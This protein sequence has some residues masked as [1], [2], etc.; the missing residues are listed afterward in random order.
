M[1]TRSHV[2]TTV[3]FLRE[4]SVHITVFWNVMACSLVDSFKVSEELGAFIIKTED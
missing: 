1:V 4:M 3:Q 2:C